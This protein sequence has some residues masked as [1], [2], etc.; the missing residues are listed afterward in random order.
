MLSGFFSKD[1]IL[2]SAYSS[3]VFGETVARSLWAVGAATAL[4]TAVYMTRLM[5]LTFLGD[6]RAGV[7]SHEHAAEAHGGVPRESPWSMTGPL[8]LLAIGAVAAGYLG[9]PEGLSAGKI[10]NYFEHLLGPSIAGEAHTA[11]R[12]GEDAAASHS[13]EW[14]LTLISAV[15]AVAG[16][17]AGLRWFGREPLWAPP[18]L[19]EEKY[20]VDEAY[21]ATVVQP[22]KSLSTGLLWKIVDVRVIDGAVNGAG[23][24]AEAAG[25]VLR[26]LQGGLARAYVAM[27]VLGALLIIGYFVTR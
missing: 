10:P 14:L 22:I 27:V 20:R 15:I 24:L 18:K 17:L 16:I 9:V 13:L 4:L 25:A 2:F 26:Y 23:K 5:A 6:R 1:E 19:L 3:A 21:D 11:V 7:S 8:I 12:A